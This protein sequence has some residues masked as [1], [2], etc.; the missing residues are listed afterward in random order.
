LQLVCVSCTIDIVIVIL[1]TGWSSL[2]LGAV[3][4][5][6]LLR[7]AGKMLAVDGVAI[8]LIRAWLGTQ[9]KSSR[10]GSR[11]HMISEAKAAQGDSRPKSS[12]ENKTV[13]GKI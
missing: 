3:A 13:A 4:S 11:W 10:R 1:L 8:R 7:Y 12:P 2:L 6:L 9:A 5:L